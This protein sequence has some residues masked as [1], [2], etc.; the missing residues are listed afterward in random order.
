MAD[1]AVAP[2]SRSA[3]SFMAGASGMFVLNILS[4]A[5]GIAIWA[6]VTSQGIVGLPTPM[7]VVTQAVAQAESGVLFEDALSS[8]GRVLTGFALGILVAIP[9]GFLM[10]WYRSPPASSSPMCSSSAPSRPSRSFRLPS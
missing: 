1:M 3:R 4:V 5:V 7:Q 8:V 6:I 10:G 2:A 9:V